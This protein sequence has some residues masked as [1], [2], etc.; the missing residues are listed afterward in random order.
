[1]HSLSHLLVAAAVVAAAVGSGT[2][3]QPASPVSQFDAAT[4]IAAATGL[5]AAA[6]QLVGFGRAYKAFFDRGG[7]EYV[8]ALGGRAPRNMPLRFTLQSVRRGDQLLLDASA[9]TPAGKIDGDRV[10]YDRGDI[11]EFY[12][13]RSDGV[14]QLFTFAKR[15]DGDGDLVVRGRIDTELQPAANADG[16]LGWQLAGVGG[17][18]YGL[19]TG[20]DAGGRR[21]AGRIRRDGGCIELSLPSAFVDAASYPLTLDPLLGTE[22]QVGTGD[23]SDP[24]VAYDASN[25]VYLVVWQ[26]RYSTF[27]IDVYGQRLN[28]NTGANLGAAFTLDFTTLT[29]TAPRVAS[30]NS[31]DQFLC[32]WQQGTGAFGPWDIAGRGVD[33]ATGT[34]SG[35]VLVAS[36][37]DNE[38]APCI[39]GEASS[40][41][42]NEALVGWR[43][44]TSGG[45]QTRQVTVAASVD[46][47]PFAATVGFGGLF[48]G[49]PSMS[50]SG[51]TV[52]RHVV[53]WSESSLV[54]D[55]EIHAIC[56]D[57]NLN[58][59]GAEL[60]VTTNTVSDSFPAVDGDG[61]NFVIAWQQAETAPRY[62]VR[63]R[64]LRYN[65]T[66]LVNSLAE[67][68][69]AATA[70]VDEATPDICYLGRKYGVVFRREA[71]TPLYDDT[72]L[73]IVEGTNLELCGP[74]FQLDG[75]NGANANYENVMRCVG[76]YAGS[77][78]TASDEGM[79]AFGEAL[80]VPPFSSIVVGQRFE[81]VGPGGSIVN[82][83]GGCGTF[84]VHDTAGGG[85]ALGNPGFT[86]RCSGIAPTDVTFLSLAFASPPIGCAS[87]AL[88]NPFVF[89]FILN[90]G[91]GTVSQVIPLTC[92]P[93]FLG[94][95]LD[96]QWVGF[97]T[98]AAPCPA[99]PGLSASNRLRCT[100]QL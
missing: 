6:G 79:I 84:G 42:D 3:Q 44:T 57:R 97:N 51:G 9:A 72:Y 25:N 28:G 33:A 39:S 13:V 53:A 62:N 32:V 22:F 49:T 14:E 10:V 47:A 89:M 40:S 65:G 16:S 36:T 31:T 34:R 41:V 63:M 85:F 96:S 8:P 55:S 82:L 61:T 60:T 80:N 91:T 95:Q 74:R 88:V 43:N 29:C 26:T 30:V 69:L 52:G 93:T 35:T 17:V 92:D 94:L 38:T 56:V 83:G 100:L 81:G 86:Y 59:L 87:C 45:I 37:T 67:R 4:G 1:M 5:E 76:K 70:G 58:V 11:D 24:D 21:V 7:V 50:K 98:A 27:D 66:N 90:P 54:G 19:V 23:N 64:G 78:S 18:R 46:P 71:G 73:Q 20:I 48:S 75:L 68:S 99:A 15:I 77:G 2:A 12:Q